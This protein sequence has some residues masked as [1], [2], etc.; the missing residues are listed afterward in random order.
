MKFVIKGQSTTGGSPLCAR[1]KSSH[2]INN[3]GQGEVVYCRESG[4]EKRLPFAVFRCNTYV[5]RTHVS[6]WDMEKIAW[7]LTTDKKG[8]EVGFV[9]SS[10][11][12]KDHPDEKHGVDLTIPN[13][14]GVD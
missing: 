6:V 2:I 9:K 14:P 5:P 8:K 3:E 12:K 13:I 4:Y 10:K 1:C 11:Y 7:I